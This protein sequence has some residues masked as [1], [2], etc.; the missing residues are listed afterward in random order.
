MCQTPVVL[1]GTYNCRHG[2]RGCHNLTD[3]NVSTDRCSP[4][5]DA[6][7]L[8]SGR[9][10]LGKGKQA[11]VEGHWHSWHPLCDSDLVFRIFLE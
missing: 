11:L 2:L 7:R 8:G 6:V 3:L 5:R 10:G 9:A 1:P 4:P